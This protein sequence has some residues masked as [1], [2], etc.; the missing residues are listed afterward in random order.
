MLL[1]EANPMVDMSYPCLVSSSLTY[2]DAAFTSFYANQAA[3]AAGGT[4][5]ISFS[6]LG[7]AAGER[8]IGTFTA[9]MY[10]ADLTTS[11]E[12]TDGSFDLILDTG[13]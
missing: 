7:S 1:G 13:L 12:V 10:A 9:T 3:S 11:I 2:T 4:C 8:I 5:G 6:T